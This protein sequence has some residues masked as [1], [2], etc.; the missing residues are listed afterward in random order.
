MF[1]IFSTIK[2]EEGELCMSYADLLRTM[3]PYNYGELQDKEFINKYLEKHAPRLLTQVDVNKDGQISFTEFFFF[4]LMLQI[5]PAKLR[6]KF[7]KH[8]DGKMTK[9]EFSIAIRELRI[10]SSAGKKQQN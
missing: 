7:K 8:K 4:M 9:E 5:P 10:T 2:T 6:K 3:T 1:E